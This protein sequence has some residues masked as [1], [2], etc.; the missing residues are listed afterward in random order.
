[1]LVRQAYCCDY[2]VRRLE[3]FSL[4]GVLALVWKPHPPTLPWIVVA[5]TFIGVG[6]RDMS[7][8]MSRVDFVLMASLAGYELIIGLTEKSPVE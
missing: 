8:R 1:M 7:T 5:L 4:G 2:G 6:S 3:F